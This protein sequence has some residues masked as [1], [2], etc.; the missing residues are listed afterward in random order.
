MREIAI[1]IGLCLLLGGGAVA[2]HTATMMQL[3]Y[4]GAA[5]VAG[6]LLFSVPFAVW[7]HVRLYR[8]L[9]PRGELTR[10]WILNPTSFHSKLTLEERDSVL[11]WF[12][13]GAFGWTVSV[14]GLVALGLSLWV[15]RTQ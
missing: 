2:V 9:Q 15:G 8:A 4:A 10:T 5:L 3:L 12:Y 7:Y 11:P 14:L 6:G 13:L 1:V